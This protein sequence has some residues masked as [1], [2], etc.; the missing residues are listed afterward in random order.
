MKFRVAGLVMSSSLALISS[1][2]SSHQG[3]PPP[4]LL[5]VDG[6]WQHDPPFEGD[7][8]E[9]PA[10]YQQ[11]QDGRQGQE[12]EYSCITSQNQAFPEQVFC[13]VGIDGAI[14]GHPGQVD[15]S[16]CKTGV[17]HDKCAAADHFVIDDDPFIDQPSQPG[18]ELRFCLRAHNEDEH[19]KRWWRI[20]GR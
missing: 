4:K 6:D 12:G 16:I 20:W 9:I 10:R 1:P 19:N 5:C 14:K 11:G 18:N 13:T 8:K 17:G 7:W 15:F 3:V 2:S